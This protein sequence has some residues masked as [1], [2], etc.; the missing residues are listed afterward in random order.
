MIELS[1]EVTHP[2]PGTAVIALKGEHDVV[3]GDD[4]GR[5]FADLIADNDLVVVDVSGADFIDSS[6]IH[7]LVRSD[8][9]ARSEGKL[10]RIQ[11]GTAPIVLRALEIS[12]VLRVLDVVGSSE[13]ALS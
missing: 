3:T 4:T 13:E 7:T 6:F 8:Q 10:F 9:M 1:V 5:L 2:Q 11:M 12:G